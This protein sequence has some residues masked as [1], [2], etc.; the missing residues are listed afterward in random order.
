MTVRRLKQFFE[1]AHL[2]FDNASCM[3]GLPFP[4]WAF[5]VLFVSKRLTIIDSSRKAGGRHPLDAPNNPAFADCQ[6]KTP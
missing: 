5:E 4:T 6:P 1:V 2:H 3:D